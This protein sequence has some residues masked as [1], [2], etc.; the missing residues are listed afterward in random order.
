MMNCLPIVARPIKVYVDSVFTTPFNKLKIV[1]GFV[2]DS[3][4]E[5]NQHSFIVKLTKSSEHIKTDSTGRFTFYNL[6]EDDT[7]WCFSGGYEIKMI[8][9]R[10]ITGIQLIY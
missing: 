2:Q 8:P 9:V 10:G 1:T 4:D 3:I 5:N 6:T 7:L